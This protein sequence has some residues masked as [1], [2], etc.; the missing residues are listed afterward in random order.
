MRYLAWRSRAGTSGGGGDDLAEAPRLPNVTV[1][2][3]L[4]AWELRLGQTGRLGAGRQ[5]PTERRQA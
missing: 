4:P 2:V 5:D 1:S 3:E